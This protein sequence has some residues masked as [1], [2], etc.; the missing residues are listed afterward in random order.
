M[1]CITSDN[2]YYNYIII[3]SLYYIEFNKC[4]VDATYSINVYKSVGIYCSDL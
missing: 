3:T 2:N 4:I 1:K